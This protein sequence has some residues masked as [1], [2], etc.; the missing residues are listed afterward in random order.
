MIFSDHF[1]TAPVLWWWQLDSNQRPH[2]CERCALII[3]LQHQ[4]VFVNRWAFWFQR[5][6]ICVPVRTDLCVPSAYPSCIPLGW[7]KRVRKKSGKRWFITL[8]C[9]TLLSPLQPEYILFMMLLSPHFASVSDLFWCSMPWF[10]LAIFRKL[11][12]QNGRFTLAI[13]LFFNSPA[14]SSFG[15]LRFFFL[16]GYYF[17]IKTV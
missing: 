6:S 10:S 16:A 14:E 1:E 8:V 3:W 15:A 13:D 5:L 9:Y 2:R 4:T 7:R 12:W 11:L 17:P